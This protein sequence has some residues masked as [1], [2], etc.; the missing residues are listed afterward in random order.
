MVKLPKE[1]ENVD[2]LNHI[3]KLLT[4]IAPGNCCSHKLF[5]DRDEP[6]GDCSRIENFISK[7]IQGYE[8]APNEKVVIDSLKTEI[9]HLRRS[10]QSIASTAT[11]TAQIS[12]N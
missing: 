5:S 12:R 10:L 4:G 11:N 9:D 6:C 2:I 1:I 8:P 3:K 7:M